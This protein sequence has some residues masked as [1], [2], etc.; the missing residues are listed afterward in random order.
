MFIVEQGRHR[1]KLIRSGG[2]SVP[3]FVTVKL[4][5][6]FSYWYWD[7]SKAGSAR[8]T[9]KLYLEDNTFYSGL[10]PLVSRRLKRWGYE[11]KVEQKFDYSSD[12]NAGV[13]RINKYLQY[14]LRPYQVKAVAVGMRRALTMHSM[15]TGSGKSLVIAALLLADNVRSLVIVDSK[16]LM[17]QLAND[18]QNATGVECGLVGDSHFMPRKWTVAVTDSLITSKGLD[19]VRVVRALYFDEA[20]HVGAMSYQRIVDAGRHNVCVRRGFSGTAYR[21]DAKG[22]LLPAL[23]GPICFHISASELIEM[24]YLARPT[25]YIAKITKPVSTARYWKAIEGRCILR[26]RCRNLLGVKTILN[27]VDQDR[28][29]VG[30]VRSV[31]V[32]LPIIR[33]LLLKRLS[34]KDI[35]EIHGAVPGPKRGEILEEFQEGYKKVLLISIGTGGE[36][37][38]LSGEA[39]CGVN[40]LGGRSEIAARQMLGRLLRKPKDPNTNEVDITKPFNVLYLDYFDE[41]HEWLEKHSINRMAIYESEEAFDVRRL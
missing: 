4:I 20:H 36:G 19:L 17:Y 24:G 13:M 41:T 40:F 21:N 22:F 31:S 2:D 1:A 28:P 32:Q 8:I 18:I 35:G 10:A 5:E 38:D 16:T 14:S 9:V 29:A 11:C 26:N 30:F 37:L 23:T 25:I 15:A 34:R 33:R 6:I 27:A 7:N 39:K 3:H 12:L